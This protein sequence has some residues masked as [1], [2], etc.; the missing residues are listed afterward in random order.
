MS[1]KTMR[2]LGHPPPAQAASPWCSG[3]GGPDS[4]ELKLTPTATLF[5][6]RNAPH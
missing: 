2:G 6:V 4:A 1:V 3:G 5:N